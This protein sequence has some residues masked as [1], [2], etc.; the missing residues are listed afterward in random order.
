MGSAI[1]FLV[2]GLLLASGARA[3]LLLTPTVLELQGDG[4]KY[5]C[6]AFSDGEKTVKY[7]AP[8]GWSYPREFDPVNDA[9]ARKA[10]S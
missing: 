3:E 7:R 8:S 4:V 2:L 5:K 1:R 10:A 9:A 6:F